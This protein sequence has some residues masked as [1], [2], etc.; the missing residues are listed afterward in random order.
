ML[1]NAH[2]LFLF[3]AHKQAGHPDKIWL[4][5]RTLLFSRGCDMCGISAGVPY[6]IQMSPGDYI[7]RI[8]DSHQSLPD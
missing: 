6:P 3:F 7:L 4:Y 8:S 5:G 1:K 2:R